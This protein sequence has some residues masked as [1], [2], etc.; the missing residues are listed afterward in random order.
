[1]FAGLGSRA[2][3]E[4]VASM[5]DPDTGDRSQAGE[6]PLI[7]SESSASGPPPAPGLIPLAR[8]DPQAMSAEKQQVRISPVTQF[9]TPSSVT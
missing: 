5:S 1:M 2:L 3:G 8:P 7:K 9:V 4:L 6:P